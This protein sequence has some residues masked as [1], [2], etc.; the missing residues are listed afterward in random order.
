MM[1]AVPDTMNTETI[2]SNVI[3]K[4]IRESSG[5]DLLD[6]LKAADL[7]A[8]QDIHDVDWKVGY[9]FRPLIPGHLQLKIWGD[10]Q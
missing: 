5:V 10:V 6:T 9:P 2:G 4:L 1:D 8:L 3:L 7:V